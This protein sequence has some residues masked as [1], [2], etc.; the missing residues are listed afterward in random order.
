[1]RL[2]TKFHNILYLLA[3]VYL[4]MCPSVHQLSDLVR[5]DITP[6]FGKQLP[7]KTFKKGFNLTPFNFHNH[8]KTEDFLQCKTFVEI[9]FSPSL[10]SAIN[11]SI[12][13]TVKLILWVSFR[14]FPP[15][16]SI[17]RTIDQ[18]LLGMC[19]YL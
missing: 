1:M 17:T 4:V 6:Q 10:F 8:T 12:L 11:L 16:F 7:H 3:F 19:W 18:L 9:K 15:Y 2:T 14:N 13:S 5:H